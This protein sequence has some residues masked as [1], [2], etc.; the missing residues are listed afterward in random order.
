MY[1]TIIFDLDGTL[2]DTSEGIF[3]SVRYVE[4]ELMLNPAEDDKL[5]FFLGPPP[6]EMYK[7]IYGLSETQAIVATKKHREYGNKKAIY[8][9]HVYDGIGD[10]LSG[11]K[12]NGYKMAVATLK[13]QEI[14]EKILEYYKIKDFFE[15]IVGMDEEETYT[16]SQ[17]IFEVV[18]RLK[19]HKA[20]MIGDSEY[21]SN[22][23]K[24]AGVDFIGVLYGF[25]FD[26]NKQYSYKTVETPIDL[27]KIL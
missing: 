25:G 3:N 27:L 14:A 6:K 18:N 4:K 19:S 11:L 15:I 12:A 20:V 8:E 7:K 10:V 17:I 1:D 2:L 9:S 26:V 5:R 22:G 24:K 16:K 23:A 21:D 13:K